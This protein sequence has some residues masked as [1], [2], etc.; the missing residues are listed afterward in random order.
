MNGT[1]RIAVAAVDGLGLDG[2]V[3]PHFGHSPAVVVVDVA[4]GEIRESRVVV[5]P[6]AGGEH[7]CGMPTFI[8]RLRADVVIAGGMGPGAVHALTGAGIEV[9]TGAS[10]GIREA[11]AAYLQGGLGATA[12]C[13]GG[14]G[15]GGHGCGGHGH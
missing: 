12:T 9:A 10:G 2:Q 5:T 15:H 1:K 6:A 3:S 11:V 13:G 4:D 14:H 8:A 7:Q